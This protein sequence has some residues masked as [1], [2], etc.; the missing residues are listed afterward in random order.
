MKITCESCQSKYTVSDEK[1]QGKTVKIKCRKCGATILVGSNG[2]TTNS[3]A[4]PA[5][6]VSVAASSSADGMYTVNVSEGDQRTM[7]MAEIVSAYNDQ[8]VTADTYVWTEGMGDWQPLGQVDAIIA[9]LNSVPV[10][11]TPTPLAGYAAAS[12]YESAPAAYASTPAGFGAPMGASPAAP[13]AAAPMAAAPEPQQFA[14]PRAAARRDVRGRGGQDL[15]GGGGG[16]GEAVAVGE[17]VATSAPLFGGQP[18]PNG[19]AAGQRDENSVLFSLSALTAKA[20]GSAAVS[21]NMAAG[22]KEDSGLIDLRALSSGS[23]PSATSDLVHDNGALFPLGMPVAPVAAMPVSMEPIQAPPNRT[24][25]FIAVGGVVALAAIVGAFLIVKG[26]GQPPVVPVVPVATQAAPPPPTTPPEPTTPPP[27]PTATASATA[28]A[29]A[30]G[31]KGPYR[32]GPGKVPGAGTAKT[33]TGGATT[34]ATTTPPK[35]KGKDCGCGGD[36]MCQIRCS[37]GG[38]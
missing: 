22:A 13:M 25:I 19:P 11:G 23:A 12:P 3:A 2:I 20:G 18:Q 17:D 35:P 37:S 10:D 38:K 21:A 33:S 31:P 28:S 32:P 14:A 34:G 29:V 5:D 1:V 16:F 30:V 27:E 36:L 26:G 8:V 4:G 24:P 7:S 15:F 9:A 6:P